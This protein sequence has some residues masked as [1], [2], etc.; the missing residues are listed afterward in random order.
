M[1]KTLVTQMTKARYDELIS[2]WLDGSLKEKWVKLENNQLTKAQQVEERQIRAIAM[3][4]SNEKVYK[5]VR[6]KLWNL[7]TIY[8]EDNGTLSIQLFG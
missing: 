6:E 5:S 2:G 3:I 4:V 1:A 8:R 7:I